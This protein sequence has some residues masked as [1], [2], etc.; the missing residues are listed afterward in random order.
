MEKAEEVAQY[1]WEAKGQPPGGPEQF[2]DEAKR[3][4]KTFRDQ[5]ER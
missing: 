2:I 4:M 3:Q 1:L 5:D